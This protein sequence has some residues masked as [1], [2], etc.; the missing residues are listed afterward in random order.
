MLL[1]INHLEKHYGQ[2]KLLDI[3]NFV[4]YRGDKVAV[5]G[6]NGSG[7]TTLLRIINGDNEPDSGSVHVRGSV[8]M[9]SQFHEEE[10]VG[11]DVRIAGRLG[12]NS[13]EVHSGGEQ[14]KAR[15]ARALSM[16]SDILLADEPTTNL[17]I[18][19]IVALEHM[20]KQYRGGLL[21]VSHDRDLL[22]NV[23][24]KVLEIGKDK[25][26]L[27][28]CSYNDYVAQKALEDG[29]NKA[30]Y[31]KYTSEK[32]RLK[33]AAQA[34]ARQSAQTRKTPKRMGNS[35]ARLHKMGGQQQ[36]YKLD[37]A[38]KAAMTRL[39]QLEKVEKPWEE[40]P[41]VFDVNVKKV[42]NPILVQVSYVS[43]VYDGRRVLENCSFMVPNSKRTGLIGANGAGK[44]TLIHIIM[45]GEE[46]IKTCANLKIGYFSQ[47]ISNIDADKTILE[48]AMAESIHSE[49]FVRT[50]LARLL[51]HRDEIRKKAAVISGGE[52][53]K[54]SLAKI[55]LSDFNLLVLDEPTN[56]LDIVS[57]SA[58]ETVLSAYPGAVLFVSHDRAFLREVAQR[59]VMIKD[60]SVHTFE[61]SY[62]ALEEASTED[63]PF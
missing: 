22:S 6:S 49:C 23:C 16:Q 43:K 52:K 25:C 32:K 15:I 18:E 7:K 37:K 58:L 54:L 41:I 17:D 28:H 46:G 11:A 62:T 1:E 44:T 57:R 33:Q 14:T 48:N 36:K 31:D 24:D 50:I 26:T 40:K 38:A 55:I 4:L 10:T 20:L 39:E 56:Y 29:A 21:L 61:G 2:R 42:H 27:Y 60:K 59:I 9:I 35:E 13:C 30:A 5:V 12:L 51:F 53:V 47:N 19:G 8:Q 3:N 45:N 34:K 63:A